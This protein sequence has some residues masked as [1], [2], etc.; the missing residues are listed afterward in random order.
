MKVKPVYSKD[1]AV[2]NGW[3]VHYDQEGTLYAMTYTRAFLVDDPKIQKVHAL[4]LAEPKPI[5]FATKS[6]YMISGNY[7]YVWFMFNDS[8]FMKRFHEATR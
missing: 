8:D 5:F 1:E 3:T 6:T 7:T 4:A 2:K